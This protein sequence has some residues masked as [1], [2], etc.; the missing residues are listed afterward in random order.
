MYVNRYAQWSVGAQLCIGACMPIFN[1]HN[2]G[3][4]NPGD[5]EG[6]DASHSCDDWRGIRGLLKE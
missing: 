5:E 3:Y 1:V 4:L 6:A 2:G